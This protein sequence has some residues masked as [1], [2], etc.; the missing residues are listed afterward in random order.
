MC[1]SSFPTVGKSTLFPYEPCEMNYHHKRD[2]I[3][4]MVILKL[5]KIKVLIRASLFTASSKVSLFSP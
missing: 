3:K 4:K 5:T 2:Y 1:H